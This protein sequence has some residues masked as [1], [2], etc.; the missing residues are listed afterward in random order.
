MLQHLKTI[1]LNALLPPVCLNCHAPLQNSHQLCSGCWQNLHFI[2]SPYCQIMGTPLPFHLG[3]MA[4]STQAQADP[5]AYDQARSIAHY[6]GTM[7][8][9]I[10]KFKYQDRHEL[11][12][13]FA[14]WLALIGSDLLDKSDMILPIPLHRRRLWQRRFNQSALLAKRLGQI[15]GAPVHYSYLQRH[16]KTRPQVGLTSGQRKDNL[17]GAFMIDPKTE[18]HIRHRS[19][20][21]I[22][23]VITTGTTANTAAK[24]LKRGGAQSVYI[25]SLGLV[26]NKPSL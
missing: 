4:V 26:T 7:R 15:T 2:S 1:S 16:K 20:L 17:Q 13:L 9:L 19:I 8:A 24:T 22:D 23:D 25:L 5:P 18:K 10:H 14:T 21:L 12:Q 3:E 11:V 6:D